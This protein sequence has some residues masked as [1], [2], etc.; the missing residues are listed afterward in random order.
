MSMAGI[1]HLSALYASLRRR[2]FQAN[3]R[4]A[5]KSAILD[6]LGCILVGAPTETARIVRQ[7]IAE[8]GG[9]PQAGIL[10]TRERGSIAAAAMANGVAGHVIDYDDTNASM[11]GHPSTVLVPV[12]LSL[13]E[14]HGKSGDDVVR[15]YIIGFEIETRLGR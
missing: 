3:T 6:G 12:I 4:T 13:G 8:F 15:A 1:A 10:G 5:A 7:T 11:I 2:D 14:A 9:Q